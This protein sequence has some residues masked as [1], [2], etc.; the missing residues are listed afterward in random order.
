MSLASLC[1]Y[2]NF[3][4]YN[5][6]KSLI[7]RAYVFSSI[8]RLSFCGAYIYISLILG[9]ISLVSIPFT[10]NDISN[11]PKVYFT[12]LISDVLFI[13]IFNSFNYVQVGFIENIIRVREGEKKILGFL[14][15]SFISLLLNDVIGSKFIELLGSYLF[16]S[17]LL[18]L[19]FNYSKHSLSLLF[20]TSIFFVLNLSYVS[21]S[22]MKQPLVTL[23]LPFLIYVFYKISKSRNSFI[24]ISIFLV[25]ISLCASIINN[26]SSERRKDFWVG[27]ERMSSSEVPVLPYIESAITKTFSFEKDSDNNYIEGGWKIFHRTQILSAATWA[28]EQTLEGK[29]KD[30][31]IQDVIYMLIPRALF[32][33]KEI[34]WPGREL[35]VDLG[36]AN[37][38]DEATSS[39]GLSMQGA[40]I[41]SFGLIFLPLCMIFSALTFSYVSKKIEAGTSFDIIKL[42][43]CLYLTL[44]CVRWFEGSFSGGL[45]IFI[46][47]IILER[48]YHYSI[49]FFPR[50]FNIRQR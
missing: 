4:F 49:K 3:I 21:S 31:F 46:K 11:I 32:P 23:A 6:N 5:S 26:Y 41:R 15:L 19:L 13:Y 42:M 12:L 30:G 48:I 17:I 50:I 2:L 34:I 18:Y 44:E 47:I 29:F 36:M 40:Y 27:T 14:V 1:F 38:A 16:P 8:L 7:L 10:I 37:F 28:Y 45:N 35:S 22:Y 25:F 24:K 39:T 9:D 43:F 20:I 33:S